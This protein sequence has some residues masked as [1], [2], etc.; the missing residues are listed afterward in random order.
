MTIF[1]SQITEMDLVGAASGRAEV[2][3][4]KETRNYHFWNNWNDSKT[5][6]RAFPSKINEIN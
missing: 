1:P 3:T 6:S 4:S 5:Y 2:V